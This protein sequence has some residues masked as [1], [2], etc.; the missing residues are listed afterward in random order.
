MTRCSFPSLLVVAMLAL[1]AGCGTHHA[2][3]EPAHTD[4]RLRTAMHRQLLH[5]LDADEQ[6]WVIARS[7]AVRRDVSQVAPGQS[8]ARLRFDDG[9]EA[10]LPVA[11]VRL[12]AAL[13]ADHAA[14]DVHQQFTNPHDESGEL[15][16]RFALP[17]AA[18]VQAFVMVIGQRRIRG[19]I[20]DR[21]EA[22]ALYRQARRLG[23]RA[24]LLHMDEPGG[25]THRLSRLEPG[26]ALGVELQYHQPTEAHGD[27]RRLALPAA[28]VAAVY[29]HAADA[30]SPPLTVTLARGLTS[31][32]VKSAHERLAAPQADEV[33]NPHRL[34]FN[35]P[36][37]ETD[38]LLHY[39]VTERA[40]QNDE[41]RRIGE[42]AGLGADGAIITVD[43]AGRAAGE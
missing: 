10:A 25:F 2:A 15:M 23:H 11:H 21:D 6:L 24:S 19:V 34:T 37:G 9:R 39:R 20:R 16:Y 43:A 12:H 18:H 31:L 22:A 38:L 5:Q 7:P 13:N 40:Q 26:E 14:V 1:L 32:E 8:A 42:H 41:G 35:H 17:D 28:L 3:D 36:P 27:R 30:D 33:A 4:A 29:D